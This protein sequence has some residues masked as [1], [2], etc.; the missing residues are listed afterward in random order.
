MSV[1]RVQ[2]DQMDAPKLF[3][4]FCLRLYLLSKTLR[5]YEI[6]ASKAV[7]PLF[8]SVTGQPTFFVFYSRVA[9]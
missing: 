2:C 8:I 7:V 1:C 5:L 3:I 4:F 9:K 6:V